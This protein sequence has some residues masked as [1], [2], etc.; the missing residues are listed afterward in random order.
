[1]TWSSDGESGDNESS[2]RLVQRREAQDR[3]VVFAGDFVSWDAATLEELAPPGDGNHAPEVANPLADQAALEDE[4]F[5]FSIPQNS[6][7]DPDAAE[8]AYSASQL[9]GA[10]LP[11]WLSFDP[12][13]QR[14]SGTPANSDVAVLEITVTASDAAGEAASDSFMLKL[15]T[16]MTRPS[17]PA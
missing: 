10:E 12:E 14:F 11:A 13:L 15:S 17:R 4:L 3:R 1:M 2:E 9:D 8:L 6:F 16:S 7:T 5:S